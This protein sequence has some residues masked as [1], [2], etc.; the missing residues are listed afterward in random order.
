MT[1]GSQHAGFWESA[2]H[3]RLTR[4]R[5]AKASGVASIGN[6]LVKTEFLANNPQADAVGLETRQRAILDRLR[7]RQS[8]VSE[9]YPPAAKELPRRCANTPGR[10]RHLQER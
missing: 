3:A 5:I 9:R 1:R 10:G 2:R 7:K 6:D 8:M 4:G